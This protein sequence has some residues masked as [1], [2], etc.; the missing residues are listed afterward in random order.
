MNITRREVLGKSLSLGVLGDRFSDSLDIRQSDIDPSDEFEL[1]KLLVTA[2]DSAMSSGA[3]YADVRLTHT[4]I[5]TVYMDKILPREFIG[6]GVRSFANGSWGAAASNIL[7]E[8][9][10]VRMGTAASRRAISGGGRLE[11]VH[12]KRFRGFESQGEWIAPIIEDPFEM[13]PY[14]MQDHLRGIF[15]FLR[16]LPHTE[17]Y[18]L[19]SDSWKQLRYFCSSS[20]S[21]L[22]QTLYRSSGNVSFSLLKGS[23]KVVLV[24]TLSPAG[25]GFELF[26]GQDIHSVI[27]HAYEEALEDVSFPYQPVDVGRYPIILDALGVAGLVG[28]TIG[29]ALELDRII[30]MEANAGGTSY[31]NDPDQM[32]GDFRIG[33]SLLN[34][35]S[36]RSEPGG[37]ATVMWDDEGM[38]PREVDLVRGGILAGFHANI[39]SEI[40]TGEKNGRS[41][42]AMVSPDATVLPLIS[43]GN[44]ILKSPN[45]GGDIYN[46]IEGIE[47]GILF[48]QAGFGLD[49]QLISG[50]IMGDAYH[51]KKGKRLSRLVNAGVL[52]RTPELWSSLSRLGSPEHARRLGMR[53]SKGE[54]AQEYYFSSTAVPGLFDDC[55]VI[56]YTRK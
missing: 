44:L 35:I 22:R 21:Y 30:G 17:N 25:V 2:I 19:S 3:H 7:S 31:I 9:D 51:I 1:R 27:K 26:R 50:M 54:P 41:T 13:Y 18:N 16:T 14:E 11:Q 12:L 55:S 33:N 4:L 46:M 36:Q 48:K 32:I 49:F 37:A 45:G 34:V 53:M 5:Y 38:R 42:G 23:R 56:D 6:M 20:D 10:A 29:T 43:S 8:S 28:G 15:H 52:F 24:D 40:W 47:D 39:E